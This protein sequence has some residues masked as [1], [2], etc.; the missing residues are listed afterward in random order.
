MFRDQ[1]N[2]MKKLSI[3]CLKALL[4]R[5]ENQ[6]ERNLRYPRSLEVKEWLPDLLQRSGSDFTQK[7]EFLAEEQEE[8]LVV[9]HL[10]HSL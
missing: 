4:K 6:S 8:F 5:S 3:L 7:E 1:L 10:Q 9:E 2:L